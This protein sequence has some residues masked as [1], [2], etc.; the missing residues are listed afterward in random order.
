MVIQRAKLY[1]STGMRCGPCYVVEEFIAKPLAEQW[2]SVQT[3]F[4]EFL[5]EN[6]EEFKRNFRSI[7]SETLFLLVDSIQLSKVHPPEFFQD[8][9]DFKPKSLAAAVSCM[10]EDSSSLG[11]LHHLGVFWGSCGKDFT[12]T[13]M[14]INH[15]TK[16]SAGISTPDK[17]LSQYYAIA[18]IMEMQYPYD[19]LELEAETS[20]FH[21]IHTQFISETFLEDI[22]MIS[23]SLSITKG[24]EVKK[25]MENQETILMIQSVLEYFYQPLERLSGN[26]L[27]HE[28]TMAHHI[29]NFL[30][31]NYP[32]IIIELIPNLINLKV[33]HNKI[34]FMVYFG[35]FLEKSQPKSKEE[36]LD[37]HN[38][39]KKMLEFYEQ[40]TV[41]QGWIE[42]FYECLCG[43]D[44]QQT[45]N[46]QEKNK[47][48]LGL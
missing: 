7:Y 34:I 20:K 41:L 42:M 12:K 3:N 23:S 32:E 8:V 18:K 17:I 10:I 15:F 9:Q 37:L 24:D 28:F 48:I 5:K 38:S 1:S 2:K 21:K 27:K 4:M 22:K 14:M 47:M 30:H 44:I 25:N 40:E 43:L 31:S 29:V 11:G 16:S 36:Y 6:P 35:E 33:L 39:I 19:N 46:L 13:V 45:R 26:R